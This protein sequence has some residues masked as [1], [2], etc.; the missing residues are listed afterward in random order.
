ML[1]A[2]LHV[3]AGCALILFGRWAYRHPMR[4]QGQ[5]LLANP[6]ALSAAWVTKAWSL[7]VIFAGS[8]TALIVATTRLAKGLGGILLDL[9]LSAVLAW[10]L[11]PK[12]PR[13]APPVRTAGRPGGVLTATGRQLAWVMVAAAVAITVANIALV[14]LHIALTLAV[15]V[16]VALLASLVLF[17]LRRRTREGQNEGPRK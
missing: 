15:V 3:A 8:Y 7:L 2:A 17:L 13:S 10:Y 12:L 1:S 6:E 14:W 4:V 9:G 5:A 11:K 16:E